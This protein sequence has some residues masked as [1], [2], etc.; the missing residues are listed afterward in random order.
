MLKQNKAVGC[1]SGLLLIQSFSEA[2][3]VFAQQELVAIGIEMRLPL[4]AGATGRVVTGLMSSVGAAMFG[5]D[6]M[7]VLDSWKFGR[8]TRSFS[9]VRIEQS[10]EM[11]RRFFLSCSA[12][13][14]GFLVS[15]FKIQDFT[16]PLCPSIRCV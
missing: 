6:Q 12:R 4:F 2:E 16:E 3:P 1:R 14:R 9:N 7:P 11:R 15:S 10:R 8:R 13:M 5:F